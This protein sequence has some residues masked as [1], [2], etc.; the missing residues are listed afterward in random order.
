MFRAMLEHR[1]DLVPRWTERTSPRSPIGRGALS[2]SVQCGFESHRG[3]IPPILVG[4]PGEHSVM[5]SKEL[6]DQARRLYATGL[7][8][9]DVAR[10]M[11]LPWRTVAHWCRGDRRSTC[12]A[13]PSRAACS[14]CT[15]TL[16]DVER[17]AYLLG[18][19]LGDGSIVH[20]Q[21]TCGLAIT[22]AD[23]WPGVAEGGRSG[24]F[25]SA[26][27]VLRLTATAHRLHGRAESLDPLDVPLPPARSGQ[28]H[29]RTITLE[30]WQQEIVDTHPGAFL[31]GLIHSD[32]CR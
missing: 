27:H 1:W 31:R 6:V 21:R 19:Y 17:Y 7:T 13:T 25:R 5:H 28:K 30:Q 18:Q 15:D 4:G 32:G 3:H 24:A 29:E 14:L 9:A 23:S 2:N 16:L 12:V 22:C 20:S 10:L 11:G 8:A 26:S